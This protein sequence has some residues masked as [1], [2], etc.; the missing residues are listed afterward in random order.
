[1]LF[2]VIL[3]ICFSFKYLFVIIVFC[4]FFISSFLFR[5]IKNWKSAMNC[6]NM[7]HTKLKKELVKI[8][9]CLNKIY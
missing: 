4:V 9:T 8:V 1:M 7:T 6:L 3:F 5:F 2:Y